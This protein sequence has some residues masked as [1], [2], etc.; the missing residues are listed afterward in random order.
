M[1]DAVKIGNNLPC[2]QSDCTGYQS[3]V[4]YRSA[5]VST[6]R[7]KGGSTRS[8]ARTSSKSCE[9]VCCRRRS[10]RADT[11]TTRRPNE[12]TR[13]RTASTHKVLSDTG[14]TLALGV[15]RRKAGAARAR[16]GRCRNPEDDFTA[17]IKL[18][19]DVHDWTTTTQ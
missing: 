3:T 8:Q 15:V 10:D 14:F 13:E 17:S 12:T 4:G 9:G 5:I 7:W 18:H 19:Q 11:F 6:V 16:A 1:K 2:L